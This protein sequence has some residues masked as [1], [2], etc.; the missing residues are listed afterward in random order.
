MGVGNYDADEGTVRGISRLIHADMGTCAIAVI[1]GGNAPHP[2]SSAPVNQACSAI[3]EEME[4]CRM[5]SHG[6]G[7]CGAL[8]SDPWVASNSI[9]TGTQLSSTSGSQTTRS[10]LVLFSLTTRTTISSCISTQF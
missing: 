2:H 1:A 3:E 8:V 5:A 6:G 4:R 10:R 9:Y 7:Q